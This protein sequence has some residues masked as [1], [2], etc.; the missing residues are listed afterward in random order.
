[1]NYES[2]YNELVEAVRAVVEGNPGLCKIDERL[3]RLRKLLPEK[4]SEDEKIRKYIL[5]ACKATIEVGD[6]G[7]ELSM[8]TT[9]KLFAYLEKQKHSISGLLWKKYDENFDDDSG[10]PAVLKYEALIRRNGKYS[11]GFSIISGDEYILIKDIEAAITQKPAEWGGEDEDELN[12]IIAFVKNDIPISGD[13]RREF[14]NWLKSLPERFNVQPKQECREEQNDG[15]MVVDKQNGMVTTLSDGKNTC[16]T[17]A[18]VSEYSTP[19]SMVYESMDE[20]VADA[21]VKMVNNSNL[22]ERDKCNCLV[23]IKKQKMVHKYAKF[24]KP[25]YVHRVIDLLDGMA[26]E[27]EKNSCPYNASDLRQ[28]AAFLKFLNSKEKNG[29]TA[30]DEKILEDIAD[31]LREYYVNKKGYPYVMEKDSVEMNEMSF[32]WT[33]PEKIAIQPEAEWTEEDKNNL[34]EV[35]SIL[36]ESGQ[37]FNENYS[38]LIEWLKSFITRKGC[39][40]SVLE[41]K[42]L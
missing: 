20:F 37:Y 23:W 34:A 42:S 33:L 13:T 24:F 29:W 2:K 9:K 6:R 10:L 19:T 15:V 4:E 30:E 17:R 38:T 3:G 40:H 31:H 39:I 12:D 14:Y 27:N 18:D 41:K 25:D 22:P 28:T 21:L 16:V 36:N 5:E 26:E 7:L 1:M 8:D 32:L 35:I 11:L